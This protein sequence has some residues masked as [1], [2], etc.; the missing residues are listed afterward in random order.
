MNKA[1]LIFFC[2]IFFCA[3]AKSFAIFPTPK[4][5]KHQSGFFVL[6]ASS[7]IIAHQPGEIENALYLDDYLSSHCQLRL[8]I[9]PATNTT[10]IE[11]QLIDTNESTS[12]NRKE[13]Y[14]CVVTPQKVILKA[15][16]KVG[17]FYA[18]QSFIQMLPNRA[19]DMKVKDSITIPCLTI[20]DYPDVAYRGMH[21]DVSRH[22][23]NV[24][25]IEKYIDL[26]A[27]NKMNYFHWHLTDDQ[28]WRIEIKKYPLLTQ[29]GSI[30][31]GTI[32]GLY[33]G[34]G[35][36]NE[37]YGG[38]YTQD[39]ISTVVQ[40]AAKRSIT[41]I[42]EI[43]MPGHCSAAIA[44]YPFLSCFPDSVT[45]YP[46]ECTWAGGPRTKKEV[47]QTWGIFK[48]ISAPTTQVLN[49]YHDV[50]D[51]VIALFPSP[52]IHIGGDEVK[53]DYWEAS[54]SAQQIMQKE[55]LK[56]V[57]DLEAYFINDMIAYLKGKGK[58]TIGWDEILDKDVD[59]SAIVMIWNTK[60]KIE[61]EA[62]N[63]KHQVILA[64]SNYFYLNN[65]QHIGDT[66]LM[67]KKPI[68][69]LKDILSF[70]NDFMKQHSAKL[71][72]IEGCLW[73]EYIPDWNKLLYFVLPRLTAIADKGWNFNKKNDTH[74]KDNF[75]D[76][77]PELM[78]W[79][80]FIGY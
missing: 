8:K 12:L 31:K 30:R 76:H 9:L 60:K 13:S 10:S 16:T 45:E 70:D 79:Y 1:L 14:E 18:I 2:S 51:E 63:Y 46:K 6:Q 54:D 75:I 78:A 5:I 40:Y 11:L 41:V 62:V 67:Y 23:F 39:D 53:T 35:N 52:Y 57:S 59:T 36:T 66:A 3:T 44:A 37:P 28:G 34:N 20:Y 48:D 7:A 72:G 25:E 43:E 65:L 47:Q 38:Y 42:P 71:L 73:T 68:L 55:K 49:F 80:H 33:P 56:D 22:F 50:L 32:T 69:T 21:L 15:T 77:L 4:E 17:L 26:L 27:L 74:Y 24:S 58:R 61:S 29:V 19:V 64:P